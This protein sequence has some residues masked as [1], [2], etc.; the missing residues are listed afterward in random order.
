MFKWGLDYNI[1]CQNLGVHRYHKF[2]M[3]KNLMDKMFFYDYFL[4]T[5]E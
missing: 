2:G 1:V 5:E 4:N 3:A